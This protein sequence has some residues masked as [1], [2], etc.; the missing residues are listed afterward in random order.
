M[1]RSG[2]RAASRKGRVPLRRRGSARRPVPPRASLASPTYAVRAPL[3]RWLASE[4][5]GLDARFGGGCRLLDVGCGELPYAPLFAG[6][7]SE[8]VGLDFVDNPHAS[9]KGP[10]EALPVPD[11]S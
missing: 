10:A 4:A 2:R 3:A 6:H 1:R 11:A 7:V 8:Y 5:G 9:L